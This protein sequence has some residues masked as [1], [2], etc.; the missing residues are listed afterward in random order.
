MPHPD[1]IIVGA[2][3]CGTTALNEYLGANPAV[4]MA[5]KEQHFFGSDLTFAWPR[6][7]REE[8][9]RSFAEGEQAG[10]RGE[11][12][13][14]YL[15]STLAAAEIH[16]HN[17]RARIIAMVRNPA[18]MLYSLHGH[19]FSWGV[20]NI[21]DFGD[22][23]AAE[24]DREQG[25]RIP[26]GHG[27]PWALAYTKVA[28]FHEQLERYLEAFGADQVHV[29]LYD[30]LADDPQ[31]TYSRVLSFLGVDGASFPEFR[32]VNANRHIRNR[33]LHKV[34]SSVRFPSPGLR[35]V[36]RVAVP[37]R[38][39]RRA[40]QSR[41]VDVAGRGNVVAG[42][43]PPLDPRLRASLTSEFEPEIKALASLI[44]RDLDH[45]LSSPDRVAA[46]VPPS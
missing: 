29:V 25:R 22:A 39:F 6:T 15:Y 44:G 5:R 2:P 23:L 38:T 30:D 21:P 46:P 45:W 11:A 1:F 28:R 36:A 18:D 9:L 8:Y 43:R 20:E 34:V 19:Y 32:V 10:L 41:F 42:K 17:P 33:R 26:P 12:S 14:W 16:A 13:V 35:R 4:F 7:T 27:H 24:H 40:V 37:S 3:K 31:G